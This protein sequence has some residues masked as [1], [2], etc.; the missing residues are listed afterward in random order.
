M[1][2]NT[3]GTV[4]RYWYNLLKSVRT[5]KEDKAKTG[6]SSCSGIYKSQLNSPGKSFYLRAP[7]LLFSKN[8]RQT[9]Y[10]EVSKKFCPLDGESLLVFCCIRLHYY[11]VPGLLFYTYSIL[12]YPILSYSITII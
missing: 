11:H 9:M 10:E 12:S 5:Q 6:A 7:S 8:G 2:F 3:I 1:A 4:Q